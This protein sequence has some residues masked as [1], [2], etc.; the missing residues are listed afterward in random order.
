MKKNKKLLKKNY[1][2]LVITIVIIFLIY[3]GI[4]IS[5]NNN[6]ILRLKRSLEINR[7][8]LSCYEL[9]D[10]LRMKYSTKKIN[11]SIKIKNVK[12][13]EVELSSLLDTTKLVFRISKLSC[14]SCFEDNI[15]LIYK[16]IDN[17]K[18]SFNNVI[19]LINSKEIDDLHRFK[20]VNKLKDHLYLDSNNEFSII[21][22]LNGDSYFLVIDKNFHLKSF[23]LPFR[24]A[25]SITNTY[26]ELIHLYYFK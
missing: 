13:E 17:S 26:L 24:N 22:E 5:N 14:S 21:P 15:K 19:I 20:R 25:K 8:K 3:C 11:S 12:N 16:Y 4:H 10:N 7:I 18:I 9:N 23:F 6:E 2:W 1:D